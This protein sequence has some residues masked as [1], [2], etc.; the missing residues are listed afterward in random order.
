MQTT[1]DVDAVRNRPQ[2]VGVKQ[3]SGNNAMLFDSI[4]TDTKMAFCGHKVCFCGHNVLVSGHI[5]SG[6]VHS[7]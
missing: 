5:C 3:R 7:F 2:V 4:F 1:L 6:C